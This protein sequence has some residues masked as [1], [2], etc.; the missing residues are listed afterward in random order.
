MKHP[1]IKVV[2]FGSAT[3]DYEHHSTLV[4][5][6]HYRAPEVILGEIMC[7][8]QKFVF[9]GVMYVANFKKN[10]L[11]Y[12]LDLLKSP[13]LLEPPEEAVSKQIQYCQCM[14]RNI[15]QNPF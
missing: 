2:D 8:V 6:R 4:S 13:R 10:S 5:T 1:E 11:G 12:T 15:S 9:L 3:Y 14:K 7:I